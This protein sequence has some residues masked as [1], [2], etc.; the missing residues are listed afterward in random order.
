M[1]TITWE[2]TQRRLRLSGHCEEQDKDA[3]QEALASCPE[4]RVLIVDLTAVTSLAPSVAEVII[5]ARDR[6]AECRVNVMRR[7]N[8]AADQVLATIETR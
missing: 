2:P 3:V 4:G 5:A 7:K 1:C 6:S 8:S